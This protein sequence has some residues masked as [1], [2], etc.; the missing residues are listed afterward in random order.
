MNSL[1]FLDAPNEYYIDRGKGTIYW[2]PVKGALT[3]QTDV[4]VS[5]LKSVV[6]SSGAKHTSFESMRP[7]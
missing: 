1:A 5:L 7:C 2:L 3:A 4:V 6:T